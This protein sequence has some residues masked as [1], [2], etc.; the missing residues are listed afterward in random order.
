MFLTQFV[1]ACQ[2]EWVWN[3]FGSKISNAKNKLMKISSFGPA[4]Q[5]VIVGLFTRAFCILNSI[6]SYFQEY[7]DSR[8]YVFCE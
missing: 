3:S 5:S 6:G 4:V 2:F 8:F 7:F 1:Y